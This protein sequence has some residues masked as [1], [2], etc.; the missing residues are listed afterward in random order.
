MERDMVHSRGSSHHIRSAFGG[1][2]RAGQVATAEAE[3]AEAEV[4]D[5]NM[6]HNSDQNERSGG[7][8]LRS[9]SLT[10]GWFVRPSIREDE[11]RC[12]G[13]KAQRAAICCRSYMSSPGLHSSARADGPRSS[14]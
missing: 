5:A 10:K 3:A 11:I 14:S 9:E 12:F 2:G 4:A 13:R 8:S 6:N 1:R 7:E